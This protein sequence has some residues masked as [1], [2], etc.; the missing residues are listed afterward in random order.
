L[1]SDRK[2]IVFSGNGCILFA[3]IIFLRSLNLYIDE[4]YEIEVEELV[5]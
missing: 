5:N 4:V 2:D 1:E 3:D